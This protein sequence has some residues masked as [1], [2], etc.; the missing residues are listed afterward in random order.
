MRI[1]KLLPLL[2]AVVLQVGCGGSSTDGSPILVATTL[3]RVQ[4]QLQSGRRVSSITQSLASAGI[5]A[6][7]KGCTTDG[8]F[9]PA[10]CGAGTGALVVYEI[11][12]NQLGAAQAVGFA[13]TSA[14]P[15]IR[16]VFDCPSE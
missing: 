3:D 1:G 7:L 15:S 8:Y 9:Y 12:S 11:G 2:A 14:W 16:S 5:A 10:V 13:P 4:C 6:V